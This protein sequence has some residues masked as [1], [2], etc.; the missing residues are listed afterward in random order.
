MQKARARAFPMSIPLPT[1]TAE[2][3]RNTFEMDL[4]VIPR[5]L[6]SPMVDMFSK[7]MIRSPEIILKPATTVISSRMKNTLKS[8]RFSQSKI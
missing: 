7:S 5:A 8:I 1:R 2:L 4:S 6:R 3:E